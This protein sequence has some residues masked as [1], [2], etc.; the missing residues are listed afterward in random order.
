MMNVLLLLG[1]AMETDH[2][3]SE[4]RGDSSPPYCGRRFARWIVA[5]LVVLS[6]SGACVLMARHYQRIANS[7]HCRNNLRQIGLGLNN[8][9]EN[10]AYKNASGSF[11]P[12]YI[13]DTA[14]SPAHSWRLMLVPYYCSGF[15]RNYRFSEPWN[16]PHN[17]QHEAREG[18]SYRSLYRCPNQPNHG[19]SPITNYVA[20]VGPQTAFPGATGRS[21]RDFRRGLSHTVFVVEYANSDIHWMEPRDL[22]LAQ[23]SLRLNDPDRP[24][25][26]SKDPGGP[27]VASGDA[28]VRRLPESTTPESL[29]ALLTTDGG[30]PVT[31]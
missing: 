22:N 30:E 8:Y 26:S 5:G 31:P 13:A 18:R 12:A 25:V 23:M 2:A 24:S 11:P 10:T 15:T 21:P 9:M 7:E 3:E 20:V 1:G 28:V 19:D 27:A 17:L 16:S 14:G 6:L 4:Q 29:R